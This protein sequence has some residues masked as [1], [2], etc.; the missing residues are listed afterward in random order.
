[1]GIPSLSFIQSTHRLLIT[2]K[3]AITV[4]GVLAITNF[5]NGLDVKEDNSCTADSDCYS[6]IG[7]C[8]SKSKICSCLNGLST[9]PSCL[10][11]HGSNCQD[12]CSGGHEYCN[13]S[14]D[15][16]CKYGG[17]WPDNCCKNQCGKYETC[18]RG[19]CKCKYGTIKNKSKCIAC[20]ERC[21][22]Y[23]RCN[24]KSG[25]CQCKQGGKFPACHCGF[26]EKNCNS[27]C[28]LGGKC[29]KIRGI[30]QCTK[31]GHGYEPKQTVGN[32]IQCKKAEKCEDKCGPGAACKRDALGLVCSGCAHGYTY[33][34]GVCQAL[35]CSLHCGP[36]GLCQDLNGIIVCQQCG[37]GYVKYYNSNSC[38][39]AGGYVLLIGGGSSIMSTWC[40]QC[41]VVPHIYHKLPHSGYGSR[42]AIMG[43]EIFSC[44][45]DKAKNQCYSTHVGHPTWNRIADMKVGRS[46][47][48]LT[49][50]GQHLVATGGGSWQQ[51]FHNSVEIYHSG[52]W[53]LASWKLIEPLGNHRA[54][55]SS[56][57]EIV[58]LG[59]SD[60]SSKATIKV[61]K[62]N[63]FTGHAT[64]MN[65]LPEV[66][67]YFACT[68]IEN[69]IYISGGYVNNN[70]WQ[71]DGIRWTKLPSLLQARSGA[72]LVAL[73]DTLYVLGGK[74][75]TNWAKIRTVEK[76]V[77]N[78]WQRVYPDLDS[79]FHW[80]GAVLINP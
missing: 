52:Q 9:Y 5:S 54:V 28:G 7:E 64:V 41:G 49:T 4:I 76:L 16:M 80:G 24:R 63:I 50:V 29:I 32:S 35:D 48:T 31:C 8:N 6:H 65:P 45:G 60:K 56:D 71:Y 25:T 17:I 18:L 75:G 10:L 40:S 14:G 62:Y 72:A 70:V 73:D 78:H 43:N 23:G 33:K 42:A 66:N 11:A 22:K 20:K 68:N 21:G 39:K 2:M 55:S 77:G 3:G 67:R 38:H 1:M 46:Y 34:N 47:H 27:H 37:Q 36:G 13:T 61:T 74:V 30:Q 19:Q 57:S 53:N 44:G 69:M 59:G 51:G 58:V 26:N 79:D 12:K 15:C